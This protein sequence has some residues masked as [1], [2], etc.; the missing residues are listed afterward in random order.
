MDGSKSMRQGSSR[1]YRK[2]KDT[3]MAPPTIEETADLE[4]SFDELEEA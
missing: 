4:A 1:N 2:Q 3:S